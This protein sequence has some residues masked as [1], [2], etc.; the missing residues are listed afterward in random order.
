MGI[1]IAT[2]RIMTTLGPNHDVMKL[3]WHTDRVLETLGFRD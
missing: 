2:R 1:Y 3:M